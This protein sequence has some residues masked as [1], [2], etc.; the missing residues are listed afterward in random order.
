MQAQ[1]LLRWLHSVLQ[2]EFLFM[3]MGLPLFNA[4]IPGNHHKSYIAENSLGN[5]FVAD[6]ESLT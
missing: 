3:S 5:R 4:L 1:L 2:V 6:S